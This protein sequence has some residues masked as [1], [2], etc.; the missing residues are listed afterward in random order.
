MAVEFAGAAAAFAAIDAANA[1]DPTHVVWNGTPE[2]KAQLQGRRASVWL[3]RLDPA[4]GPALQLAARAHHLRRFAIPRADYPEGRAGY[5]R[6]RRDQKVAHARAL[7]E[8]LR[9][10]GIG[11]DVLER[12]GQLLRKEGL[13]TDPETQVYEDVVCLVFCETELDELLAKVGDEK[14]RAAV[15]KTAGKMSPAGL[16]L[17]PEA[18]P[19]GPGLDLLHSL[20]G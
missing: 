14:V 18:T 1:E 12:A 4:A 3:E 13:G 10:V 16:A 7:A 5:L 17:A 9:P 20:L 8:L 6:W 19:P 11:D 2:P 15:V